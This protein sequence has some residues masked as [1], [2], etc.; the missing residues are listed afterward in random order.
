MSV[1]PTLV[2]IFAIVGNHV[3]M[4]RRRREIKYLWKIKFFEK[5]FL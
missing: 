3:E 2:I 4:F 5:F 1:S